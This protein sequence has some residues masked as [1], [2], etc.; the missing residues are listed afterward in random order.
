MLTKAVGVVGWG[1]G[2]PKF[3]IELESGVFV[4]NSIP[5]G[6]IQN[7]CPKGIVGDF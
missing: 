5:N 1:S 7:F 3:G 2:W 4:P 6:D